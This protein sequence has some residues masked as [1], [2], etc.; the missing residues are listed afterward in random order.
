M[1]HV[2]HGILDNIKLE[3]SMRI[4]LA[5]QS[6]VTLTYNDKERLYERRRE[7]NLMILFKNECEVRILLN[8]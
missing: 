8:G 2:Y 5:D 7:Y 3:G 6:I 4:G 1:V